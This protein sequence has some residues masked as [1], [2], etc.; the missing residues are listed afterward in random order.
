MNH[1]IAKGQGS[2]KRCYILRNTGIRHCNF[3]PCTTERSSPRPAFCSL[4]GFAFGYVYSLVELEQALVNVDELK[5]KF[6]VTDN[7]TLE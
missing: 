6:D 7:N 1:R 2:S 4:E 5:K 3:P